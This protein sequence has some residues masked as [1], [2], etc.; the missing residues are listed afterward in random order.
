M[1]SDG[2]D[3][4]N[5][6]PEYR[7][8]ADMDVIDCPPSQIQFLTASQDQ[9]PD[10]KKSK[11]RFIEDPEHSSDQDF[12][13]TDD[14]Y[15]YYAHSLDSSSPK[16][17]STNSFCPVQTSHIG[18]RAGKLKVYTARFLPEYSKPYTWGAKSQMEHFV[19]NKKLKKWCMY[20]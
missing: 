16:S 5:S 13:V 18:S 2:D 12:V 11:S 3:S 9:D 6:T 20:I 17:S 8:R 1:D 15:E 10:T 14:E 19:L 7:L 4:N